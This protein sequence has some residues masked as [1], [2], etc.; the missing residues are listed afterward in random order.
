MAKAS[1]VLKVKLTINYG[2]LWFI[3]RYEREKIM[4]LATA[5]NRVDWIPY[6][7]SLISCLSAYFIF[8][9]I[10]SDCGRHTVLRWIQNKFVTKCIYQKLCVFYPTFVTLLS[11]RQ[12]VFFIWNIYQQITWNAREPLMSAHAIYLNIFEHIR[13]TVAI[14]IWI[15][16]QWIDEWIFF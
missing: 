2:K 16:S 15:V 13:K 14:Q 5:R 3:F 1:H 4:K 7:L 10:S 9:D 11:S 12:E 6:K 8:V